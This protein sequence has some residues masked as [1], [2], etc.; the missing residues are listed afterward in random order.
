MTRLVSV[1]RMPAGMIGVMAPDDET[2][3]I[4][5]LVELLVPL[6]LEA[7]PKAHSVPWVPRC[8]TV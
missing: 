4:D 5:E 7:R 1:W 2:D 3:L 6:D 8:S